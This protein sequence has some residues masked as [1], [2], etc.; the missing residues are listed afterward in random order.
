[1]YVFLVNDAGG[2]WNPP[3]FTVFEC[4]VFDTP[5]IRFKLPPES[6]LPECTSMTMELIFF[7]LC[8]TVR[9]TVRVLSYDTLPRPVNKKRPA[10]YKR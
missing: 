3:R 10:Q 2:S 1:M 7:Y 9:A 5:T 4:T 8:F 6:L